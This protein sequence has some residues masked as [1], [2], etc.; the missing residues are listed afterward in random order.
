MFFVQILEELTDSY[1]THSTDLTKTLSQYS[2]TQQEVRQIRYTCERVHVSMHF[3]F[4]L[5][6]LNINKVY[7]AFTTEQ[8]SQK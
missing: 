6:Y 8:L 1:R 4:L 7:V 5:F 2:H 3:Y